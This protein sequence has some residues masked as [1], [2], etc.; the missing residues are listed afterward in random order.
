MVES[1][2]VARTCFSHRSRD[3]GSGMRCSDS[4]SC[5][6]SGSMSGA[7]VPRSRQPAGCF[8]R[9]RNP[10][11]KSRL[12]GSSPSCL[13]VERRS[14]LTWN[15]YEN[16]DSSSFK[17]PVHS[18]SSPRSFC[19]RLS[20]TTAAF[21]GD[22]GTMSASSSRSASS[23]SVVFSS[24]SRSALLAWLFIDSAHFSRPVGPPPAVPRT[25]PPPPLPPPGLPQQAEF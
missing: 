3:P 15:R 10:C 14:S 25:P 8:A 1:S 13:V 24:A 12:S 7:T 22:H 20:A 5:S 23:S 9:L 18:P 19:F 16:G 17:S 21:H 4:V 2:A 6:T 11:R